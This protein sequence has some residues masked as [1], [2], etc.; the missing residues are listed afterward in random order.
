MNMNGGIEYYHAKNLLKKAVAFKYIYKRLDL[1]GNVA[2][3]FRAACTPLCGCTAIY[4]L[5][6][7]LGAEVDRL[8]K[9]LWLTDPAT[10]TA[11][12]EAAS[13]LVQQHAK[14]IES[15]LEKECTQE[16]LYL[17]DRLAPG[18]SGI[19]LPL[20]IDILRILD[21][22]R[23]IGLFVSETHMLIPQK[24]VT[25]IYGVSDATQPHKADKCEDC[26]KKV[27]CRYRKEGRI[28]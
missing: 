24:S 23:K 2:I 13:V 5:C 16:G 26:A 18:L 19:P 22:S 25:A 10:A 28:C 4:I 7:T 15:T 14:E 20:N 8:I 27:D 17:T 12:D 11:C 6:L 1:T 3:S 21:A 9:E